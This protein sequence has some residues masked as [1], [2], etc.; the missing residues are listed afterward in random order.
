MGDD[1]VTLV[2]V[3]FVLIFAVVQLSEAEYVVYGHL[4]THHRQQ[5]V[6]EPE[7]MSSPFNYPAYFGKQVFF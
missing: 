6:T 5:P 4:T 7:A 1:I 3:P 2:R